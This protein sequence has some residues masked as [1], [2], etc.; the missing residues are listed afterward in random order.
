M[1]GGNVKQES[2]LRMYQKCLV[3]GVCM[4]YTA[5]VRTAASS[6][7]DGQLR[8]SVASVRYWAKYNDEVS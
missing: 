2:F 7:A 3:T 6:R 4:L 1:V 8:I 5:D